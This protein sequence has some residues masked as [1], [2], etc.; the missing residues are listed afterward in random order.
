MLLQSCMLIDFG[1]T[2]NDKLVS[3][4]GESWKMGIVAMCVSMYV[5]MF[6]ILFISYTNLAYAITVLF[7]NLG[8]T[9]LSIIVPHA[10]TLLT[11]AIVSL[12]VAYIPLI[13]MHPSSGL[14][15]VLG[16]FLTAGSLAYT[17]HSTSK[18]NIFNIDPPKPKG[19]TLEK[20]ILGDDYSEENDTSVLI[21]KEEE[22]RRTI[23]FYDLILMFASMYMPMVLTGFGAVQGEP[24]LGPAIISQILCAVLYSWTLIAPIAFPTRDFS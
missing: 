9:G 12:Q 17:A 22:R 20:I 3:M 19:D 23:H 16:G 14:S 1:Y 6:C 24:E 15:A 7:V 11:S 13:S 5:L 18:T 2:F 10:R 4:G 21:S 8:M